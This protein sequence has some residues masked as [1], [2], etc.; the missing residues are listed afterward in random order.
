MSLDFDDMTGG[1][2]DSEREDPKNPPRLGLVVASKAATE[3]ELRAEEQAYLATMRDMPRIIFS[4]VDEETGEEVFAN[5]ATYRDAMGTVSLPTEEEA[6]AWERQT[7]ADRLAAWKE[8]R[9]K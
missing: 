2:A 1:F 8:A 7:I 4:E 9:E 6:M 3:E 5:A